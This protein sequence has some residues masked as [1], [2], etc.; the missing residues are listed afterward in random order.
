MIFSGM[1]GWSFMQPAKKTIPETS[2]PN[3]NLT[4]KRVFMATYLESYIRDVKFMVFIDL[5]H[6]DSMTF[7]P[8]IPEARQEKH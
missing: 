1:V 6:H 7:T 5:T 2:K 4:A 8:N 3:V